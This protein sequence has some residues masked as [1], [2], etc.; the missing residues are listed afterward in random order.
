MERKGRIYE[1]LIKATYFLLAFIAGVFVM[2]NI[3]SVFPFFKSISYNDQQFYSA[4]SNTQFGKIYNDIGIVEAID[5]NV[6]ANTIIA[7]FVNIEWIVLIF[8]V[9]SIALLFIY[10][11]FIKWELIDYYLKMTA[12]LF[13]C[14]FSKYVLFALPILLFYKGTDSSLSM[15]FIIGSSL[16]IIISLFEFVILSILIIKFIF[17]FINDVK[18]IY[19]HWKKIF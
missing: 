10:F 3:I 1:M 14:Y 5:K 6:V 8:L 4:I 13:I 19:T 12:Y 7:F 9:V 2:K 16:Y 15:S 11:I 17:S 18:Y